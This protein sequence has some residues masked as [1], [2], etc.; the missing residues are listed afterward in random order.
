MDGGEGDDAGDYAEAT[1][2]VTVDLSVAGTQVTGGAG[3]DS[4]TGI[5]DLTGSG[6]PDRLVGS[7]VANT[8]TGWGG[9]DT[10]EGG[11]GKDLLQ[12]VDGNDRAAGNEGD[13]RILGDLGDDILSG[14]DGADEI[15]GGGGRDDLS[16]EQG[17]D[18]LFGE[19]DGD[20]AGGGGGDDRVL[21]NDGPDILAGGDGNDE[22]AGGASGDRLT[23]EAG[24]DKLLGEA[25]RDTLVGGE[26]ADVFSGGDGNDRLLARDGFRDRVNGGSGKDGGSFDRG[27]DRVTGVESVRKRL[28]RGY[29]QRKRKLAPGISLTRITAP[30]PRRMFVLAVKPKLA[31][32]IEVALAQDALQGFERTSQMARRHRALAAINGDF[33]LPQGR[34]AHH[35]AKDGDL[36]QSSRAFGFNFAISR[37]ELGVFIDRPAVRLTAL[38]TDINETWTVDRWNDGDP[39]LGEIA[40]HSPAGGIL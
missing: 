32:T 7:A 40:A 17:S 12:G 27:Q 37:D 25:G 14:G 22:V 38:E 1:A 24:D 34:P 10:L 20:V 16:G 8:L 36:K 21:G 15:R 35:L 2:G 11:G 33:G 13:D 39:S 3:T 18:R 9:D 31:P 26:S 4:L 6:F 19:S 5:E 30:G 29:R 23:G 28:P